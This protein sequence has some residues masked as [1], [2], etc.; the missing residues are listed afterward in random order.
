MARG[1]G[2]YGPGTG[3]VDAGG[4]FKKAQRESQRVER[5]GKEYRNSVRERR[6]K[7]ADETYGKLKVESSGQANFD[8]DT[9]NMAMEWK[10]EAN[11]LLIKKRNGEIS[12]EDFSQRMSQLSG[13]ADNFNQ[14]AGVLKET[15]ATYREKKDQVSEATPTHILDALDT[16]DKNPNAFTVKNINGEPTYVGT[17]TGGKEVEIPIASIVEGDGRWRFSE[18]IDTTAE[19]DTIVKDLDKFKQQIVT[20][21]GINEE[22]LGWD[23]LS[24]RASKKVEDMLS[25]ESKL[26]AIAADEYDI[27]FE[28]FGEMGVD[29]VRAEVGKK[30]LGDLQNQLVPRTTQIRNNP[31]QKPSRPSAQETRSNQARTNSNALRSNLVANLSVEAGTIDDGGNLTQAGIDQI[32]ERAG[33]GEKFQGLELTETGK[34][35]PFVD[36]ELKVTVIGAD[37]NA[38]QVPAT[39]EAVIN[40]VLTQ[41]FGAEALANTANN[42]QGNVTETK[43]LR[44]RYNY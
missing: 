2:A 38:F 36:N 6:Q 35:N 1:S 4:E 13:N 28:L 41:K 26:R 23:Q 5:E 14:A 29:L 32:L 20:S 37:G 19:R 7:E 18:K 11:D 25:D 21:T 33:V 30:I 40:S 17:T 39:P 16:M 8:A 15:L 24:E 12:P 10:K 42:I 43:D 31:I 3:F 34:W 22:T 27:D 44:S 9:K